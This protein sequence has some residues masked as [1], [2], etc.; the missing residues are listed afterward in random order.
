M[1]VKLFRPY[2]DIIAVWPAG[3]HWP[4]LSEIIEATLRDQ[5]LTKDFF[6][7]NTFLARLSGLPAKDG[8]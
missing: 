3:E 6:R 7:N 1:P 4:T 2:P 5:E 8:F